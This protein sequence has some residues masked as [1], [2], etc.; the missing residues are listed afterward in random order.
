MTVLSYCYSSL[1]NPKALELLHRQQTE[2]LA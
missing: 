1:K 2:V